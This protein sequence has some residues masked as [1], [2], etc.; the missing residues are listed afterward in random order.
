M[1]YFLTGQGGVYV[2]NEDVIELLQHYRHDLM[3]Q[4]QIMKG[5]LSMKKYDQVSHKLDELVEGFT[6]ER[7]L[8]NLNTPEFNLWI[9]R[10]NMW[11]K[12]IRLSYN[13]YTDKPL[14]ELDKQFV[15]QCKQVVNSIEMS[16]LASEL[17]ELTIDLDENVKKIELII[18]IKG[19]FSDKS[20]LIKNLNRFGEQLETNDEKICYRLLFPND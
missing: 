3:N 9:I 4:V 17:Y 15:S 6:E 5:Y 13:I 2:R 10:F 18:T 16:I 14:K 1:I 19:Y 20:D 12:N 11:H 7:K 8:M